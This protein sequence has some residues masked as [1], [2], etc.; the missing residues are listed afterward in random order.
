M[1]FRAVTRDDR[2]E[3]EFFAPDDGGFIRANVGL[4]GDMVQICRGGGTTG[5]PLS[6]ASEED[7]RAKARNWLRQHRS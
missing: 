1:F 5:V 3:Y 4:G 7:L 6:A 2:R